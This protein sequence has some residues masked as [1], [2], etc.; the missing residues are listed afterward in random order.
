M[1]FKILTQIALVAGFRNGISHS[2]KFYTFEMLQLRGYFVKSKEFLN[3][4][5][6]FV[7]VRQF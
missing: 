6:I 4:S 2:R 7:S 1:I 3:S 5:I